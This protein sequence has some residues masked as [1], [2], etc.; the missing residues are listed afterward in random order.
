M[1]RRFRRAKGRQES[2]VLD[3]WDGELK[4]TRRSINVVGVAGGLCWLVMEAPIGD[5]IMRMKA[6]LKIWK[7][8]AYSKMVTEFLRLVWD[9]SILGREEFNRATPLMYGG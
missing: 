8:D 6:L 7:G 5:L 2:G 3:D 9:A 4:G 1:Q